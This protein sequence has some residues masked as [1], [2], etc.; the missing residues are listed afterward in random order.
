MYKSQIR[1]SIITDLLEKVKRK[2]YNKYLYRITLTKVR[3]FSEKTVIFDFPVTALIGPNGGGKTTIL[4]AAALPYKIIKPRQYFSKSGVLDM[5][6]ADWKIEYDLI[7]RTMK[8]PGDT[9]HRRASFLSTKWSRDAIERDVRVFGV[10]RTVPASERAEFRKYASN[11]FAPNPNEAISISAPVKSAV[12]KILDRSIEGYTSIKFD[13][14]GRPKLLTGQTTDGS[15]KY[16]EF[17]FGAGESSIIRMVMG[18]ESSPDYSLVLI[19]EIENGL[20]PLATMRLVEYLIETAHRKKIQVIFTTHSNDALAPLPWEGIWAAIGNNV[21]QGKLN[22]ESLRAITGQTDAAVA[23]FTEDKFSKDWVLGMLRSK[24]T[25]AVDSIEIH[26]LGGDGTAV[27]CNL[28]HNADPTKRFSSLCLIDGDSRQSTSNTDKVYR[29]PGDMPEKYVFDKVLEK[30]TS[31]GSTIGGKLTVALQLPFEMSDKVIST[32]T[33]V[34]RETR[35]YHLLYSN[36]GEKFGLIPE[37]VI[38]GGFISIWCQSYPEEVDRIM[39]EIDAFLPKI[40]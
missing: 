5:S 37:S 26:D 18:I 15:T 27:N 2:N 38:R 10:S 9:L 14:K 19:E 25:I 13:E 6:M 11:T 34:Q 3:G 8:Y 29:L 24:T 23:I 7:D 32:L 16:S 39:S 40:H 12:E 33:D 4:G 30:V 20:H 36:L 35:D 21:S 17:H 31:P 28:Y 1:Q 22:I